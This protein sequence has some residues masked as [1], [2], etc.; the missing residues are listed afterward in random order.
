MIGSIRRA[1]WSCIGPFFPVCSREAHFSYSATFGEFS[2]RPTNKPQ[3]LSRRETLSCGRAPARFREILVQSLQF[4]QPFVDCIERGMNARDFRPRDFQHV[5]LDPLR[6]FCD[7]LRPV[8]PVQLSMSFT[9]EFL[10]VQVI[11]QRVEMSPAVL[12]AREAAYLSL[13]FRYQ[14]STATFSTVHACI[15]GGFRRRFQD[16]SAP[17]E[18]WL[19]DLPTKSP[20]P[21]PTKAEFT[22][23][24]TVSLVNTQFLPVE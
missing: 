10:F 15:I 17:I 20:Y 7:R 23:R 12:A 13:G 4:G 8:L 1:R 18:I 3:P 24:G 6:M 21:I 22:L 11:W 19:S 5:P 14:P 2:A 16:I 9:A